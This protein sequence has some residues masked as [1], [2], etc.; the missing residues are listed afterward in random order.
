[1]TLTTLRP[2]SEIVSWHAHIYFDTDAAPVSRRLRQRVEERFAVEVGPWHDAPFGP[3][4][5]PSWFFG[6]TVEQF[7]D[8][9]SWLVLNREGLRILF[10]PNTDDPYA[11]HTV[12]SLWIGGAQP[13]NLEG[14]PRSLAAIGDTPE[15]VQV[16]TTPSVPVEA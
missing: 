14:L 7:R 12:N 3:H 1:M 4:T 5:T 16:N 8:V 15:Q 2:I 13:I 10:H 9:V 11:D 6:F